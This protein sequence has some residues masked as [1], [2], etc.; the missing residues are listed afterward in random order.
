MPKHFVTF[1]QIHIHRINNKVIDRDSVA[2]FNADSP[3]EGRD[4]AFEFFGNKFFT[5][6][7]DKEWT[8]EDL[9]FFPRGYVEIE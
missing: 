7:H 8:G 4:K 5:D 6:Y 9:H 3:Q 1:G 2:V